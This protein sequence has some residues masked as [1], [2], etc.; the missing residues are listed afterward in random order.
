M[1]FLAGESLDVARAEPT[2]DDLERQKLDDC[3]WWSSLDWWIRCDRCG[4][5]TSYRRPES[6]QSQDDRDAFDLAWIAWEAHGGDT[7]VCAGGCD[8]QLELP[9]L[10]TAV[11]A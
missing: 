3:Y 10:A 5:T 8:Q 1:T 7:H 6:I 2:A 9:L 4:R 11:A